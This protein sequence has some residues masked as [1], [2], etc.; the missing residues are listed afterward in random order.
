[1]DVPKEQRQKTE[2][3]GLKK[4]LIGKGAESECPFHK[5][6]YRIYESVSGFFKKREPLDEP[7]KDQPKR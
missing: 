5:L 2:S 4:F 1:M 3:G 7:P 6:N